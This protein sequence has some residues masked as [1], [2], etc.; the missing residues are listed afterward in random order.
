M[1]KSEINSI[2]VAQLA[3][4]SR[5]TVSRVVN[6]YANVPIETKEKVMKAIKELN[7]FPNVSAQMLAGKKS[8]TIG[9]FMVSSGE[10][11]VDVLTNMMIVSVIEKASDYD[12][13]V[14]T[15]IIRDT[16]DKATINNVK[17]IFYQRRI[18]GGIFIGTEHY[19]PFVE[20]LIQEGFIIGVF[21]QEHPESTTGNRIVANFNNELGMK[22][23]T[24][25]LIG[26]GHREIGVINGNIKRLSGERKYEGFMQA[27]ELNSLVVNPSWVVAAD[28]TDEAGYKAMKQLLEHEE[29]LP[30][31]FIAANDS[32][33]FGAI[34]AL[35]EQNIQVPEDISVIGFDDH[36]LS[37][38]HSPPLT[39]VKVDF[40][41]L[42]KDLLT[43]LIAK[44]EKPTD[45]IRQVS[46]DC[47]LIIRESCLPKE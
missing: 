20:E 39:T 24:D 12:Y 23:A 31:A 36:V 15:Y 19:E 5:S 29:P 26:L 7:Y 14:L 43:V 16:T 38:K 4:V 34:R 18:D 33:A 21:D 35:R 30:T 1:K 8:R 27:M 9:L 10:V 46:V 6:N 32:I 11:S 40:K 28:F 37:E 2:E 42:F 22:Q 13:Y 3:G 47:S 41:R 45:D 25:Y 17:E 44:I